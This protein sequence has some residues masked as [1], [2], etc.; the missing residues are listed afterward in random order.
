[1]DVYYNRQ[2][3]HSA[4]GYRPPEEFERQA[5]SSSAAESRSVTLQFFENIENSKNPTGISDVMIGEGDSTAVLFVP[6]LLLLSHLP[7]S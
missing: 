4:L 3:L 2:Q 5:Q 7:A 1:M 6:P